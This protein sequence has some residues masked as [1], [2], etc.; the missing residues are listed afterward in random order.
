MTRLVPPTLAVLAAVAL[1]AHLPAA[2]R[3]AADPRLGPSERSMVRHV[4]DVRARQGVRPLRVSRALGRA[5]DRHSRDMLRRDFFDHRSSDG[6]PF[7]RRV[8]RYADARRVGEMLAALGRRRGGAAAVVRLWM[9]SPPHRAI[10]L[11]SGF[12][13]IGI[14][15]RWGRLGSAKQ[16]VVTADLASAR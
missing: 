12:R 2:P 8:R 11:D 6:T 7:E 4:N 3:A 14:A 5:A 10:L 9:D 16:A 1:A 15:R 13:R